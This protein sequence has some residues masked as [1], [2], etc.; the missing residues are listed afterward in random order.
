M[1]LS[2]TYLLLN[3][4]NSTHKSTLSVS[5]HKAQPCI[6]TYMYNVHTQLKKKP[7]S[8]QIIC[9]YY[10]A[11]SDATYCCILKYFYL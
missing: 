6:C 9:L 1:P 2:F 10:T 5:A 11:I 4:T 8:I 3:T 7:H